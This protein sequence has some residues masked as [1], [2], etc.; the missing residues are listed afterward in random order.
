[1]LCLSGF[2]LYSRWV[3]LDVRQEPI[4]WWAPALDCFLWL[5]RSDSSFIM[6]NSTSNKSTLKT[7]CVLHRQVVHGPRSGTGSGVSAGFDQNTVRD[8]SN[9]RIRDLTDTEEAWF[10]KI[11]TRMWYIGKE[12]DIRDSDDITSGC[13]ILIKKEAGMRDQ[14]SPFPDFKG[15]FILLGPWQAKM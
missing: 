9:N 12:N 15:L 13:E 14:E 3:P 4:K 2:E 1:M 10:A 11:L 8:S 7:V 5:Q 6:L